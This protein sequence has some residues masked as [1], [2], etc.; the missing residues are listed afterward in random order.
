MAHAAIVLACMSGV[1]LGACAH[2]PPVAA[3]VPRATVDVA[4]ARVH[5]PPA[6]MPDGAEGEVID[7]VDCSGHPV[8]KD[9]EMLAAVLRTLDRTTGTTSLPETMELRCDSSEA[10]KAHASFA[11]T[12]DLWS[13]SGEG[14]AE[15]DGLMMERASCFRRGLARCL[16]DF[17]SWETAEEDASSGGLATKGDMECWTEIFLVPVDETYLA[18]RFRL[19]CWREKK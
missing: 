18:H 7:N 4:S 15:D 17:G 16:A 3:A 5:P 10:T 6:P 2:R 14:E 13:T 8:F 11:C 1:T 19:E 12:R 9:C